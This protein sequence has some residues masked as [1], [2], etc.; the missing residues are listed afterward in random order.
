MRAVY[1]EGFKYMP[2]DSYSASQS[3]QGETPM[4]DQNSQPQDEIRRLLSAV[5]ALQSTV[6]RAYHTGMYNVTSVAS[7]VKTYRKLHE[8]LSTLMSDDFYVTEALTFEADGESAEDQLTHLQLQVNQL[9]MYLKDQTRQQFGVSIETGD[10]GELKT[11]GRDLSEQII[12]TTRKALRRAM[13]EID[14]APEPPQP[15]VP[16]V[17]PQPPHTPPPVQGKRRIDIETDG[18]DD[19]GNGERD[20]SNPPPIV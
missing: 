12:N 10:W 1:I 14:N 11:L 13:I 17:P 15:P 20:P 16:P 7:L 3:T 19:E 2:D 6:D 4:T 18:D 8:R 5:K 9:Y